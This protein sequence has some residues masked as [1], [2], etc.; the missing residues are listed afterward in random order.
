MNHSKI[1]L[2]RAPVRETRNAAK[3]IFKVPTR[4]TPKYE[5]SPFYIG[6][7]LWD[8][9]SSELQCVFE[10]KKE[11]DKLYCTYKDLLKCNR[12]YVSISSDIS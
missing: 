8:G 1:H 11:V 2:I 3:I 10:F 9:L 12:Q 6:T 5:K 4:I 7:K